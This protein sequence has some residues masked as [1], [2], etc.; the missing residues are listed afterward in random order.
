MGSTRGAPTHLQYKKRGNCISRLHI[1]SEEPSELQVLELE[2]TGTD[3]PTNPQ[4]ISKG[5]REAES[6][7]H[8]GLTSK[9]K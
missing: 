1:Q 6:V 3:T 7:P 4:P 8:K 9:R 5:G 2:S